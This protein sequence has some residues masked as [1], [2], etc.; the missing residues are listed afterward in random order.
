MTNEPCIHPVSVSIFLI[1]GFLSSPFI[2]MSCVEL[3]QAEAEHTCLFIKS[4]TITGFKLSV[5]HRHCSQWEF[6]IQKKMSRRREAKGRRWESVC[7][8]VVGGGG[9]HPT[10]PPP[11]TSSTAVSSPRHPPPSA[12]SVWLQRN[13]VT[14]RAPPQ[15]L[16]R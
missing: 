9:G 16:P 4:S 3:L 1:Y 14:S 7:V 8:C 5:T 15:R 2:W 6:S 10:P 12:V 11:S 13:P